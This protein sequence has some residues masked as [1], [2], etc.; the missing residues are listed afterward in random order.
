MFKETGLDGLI[1]EH[2]ALIHRNQE[3]LDD[4]AVDPAAV[5]LTML[6]IDT[7]FPETAPL[8]QLPAFVIKIKDSRE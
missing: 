8:A 3:L 6:F 5:Q 2:A 4:N 7:N 1:T